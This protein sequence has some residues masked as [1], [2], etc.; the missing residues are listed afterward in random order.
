MALGNLAGK[1]GEWIQSGKW[2]LV[3]GGAAATLAI[4]FDVIPADGVEG[5]AFGAAAAGVVVLAGAVLGPKLAARFLGGSGA[6]QG[7]GGAGQG[8]KGPSE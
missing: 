3:A 4:A 8:G 7:Q 6:G 1:L 5:K 2:P